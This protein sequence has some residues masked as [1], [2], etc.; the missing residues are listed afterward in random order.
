M[1]ELRNIR[2]E[3]VTLIA[4][5]S[6]RQAGRMLI[7]FTQSPSARLRLGRGLMIASISALLG[8]SALASPLHAKTVSPLLGIHNVSATWAPLPAEG[9]RRLPGGVSDPQSA[10]PACFT[11]AQPPELKAGEETECFALPSD[12]PY[13]GINQYSKPPP[14]LLEH[15]ITCQ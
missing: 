4:L 8:L 14:Q 15:A 2:L 11:A 7:H 6:K 12:P 5:W 1:N 10:V 3:S 13:Q 9:K